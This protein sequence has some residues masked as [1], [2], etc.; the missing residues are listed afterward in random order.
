M[1]QVQQEGPWTHHHLGWTAA[2]DEG[3][4]GN[5]VSWMR[6]RLEVPIKQLLFGEVALSLRGGKRGPRDHD[7]SDASSKKSRPL[8]QVR[9][10]LDRSIAS[11]A[12]V[13]LRKDVDREFVVGTRKRQVR[14]PWAGGGKQALGGLVL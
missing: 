2:P 13:R 6:R 12:R 14:E 8:Q 1:R 3:V 11:G 7:A 5:G 4:G 10:R 9:Q